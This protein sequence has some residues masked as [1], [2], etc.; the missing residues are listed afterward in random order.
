[1]PPKPDKKLTKKQKAEYL[2]NKGFICPF[3]GSRNI[4]A[5]N[6]ELTDY[7]V[8]VDVSCADCGRSWI[9]VYSLTDVDG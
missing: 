6:P 4:S 5:D 1:M 2:K 8:D 9:D 3:C 7:G